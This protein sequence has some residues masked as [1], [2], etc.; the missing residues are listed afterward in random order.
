M[1][2]AERPP[3]IGFFSYS[4]EDDEGRK[5]ALSN[6]RE[7]IQ[8][9]LRSHL[10][11]SKNDCRLFQ[12]REEIP[13]GAHWKSELNAAIAKSVFFI[14]IILDGSGSSKSPTL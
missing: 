7:R 11:R 6:L 4:R 12:D 1:S 3:I 13:H 14:P 10:G 9:E 8:E 2:L 5:N